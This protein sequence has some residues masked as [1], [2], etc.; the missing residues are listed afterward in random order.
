MGYVSV[1]P[2]VAPRG[3]DVCQMSDERTERR[4]AAILAA[5]VAGYSRLIGQ[6][7][8]RTLARLRAYRREVI[9]PE[10]SGH[11][12][13]LVK[14]TG[15]GFLVEFSS[16]LEALRC[17]TGI[18]QQMAE[19]N[20]G[21]ADDERIDLR[22]GI[23]VGD[24]VVENADIF[25]DGVNVAAR[26][27]EFAA[28]GGICVSGRVHEDA[29]GRLSLNFVDL[30]DQQFKNI[31]HPVRVFAL[32]PE[33]LAAS[34]KAGVPQ[35]TR[36]P[37]VRS[38]PRWVFALGVLILLIGGTAWWWR[39]HATPRSIA[40]APAPVSARRLSVIVLPFSNLS[41]DPQKQYFAD[42]ITEDLTTDLSRIGDSFVI[43]RTTAFTFKDKPVSA[44]EIGQQLGVRYVLE[45]S[46]QPLGRQIRV[47]AQLIEAQTE[48]HVWSQR[49]DRDVANLSDLQTDIT[50]QIAGALRLVLVRAEASRTSNNPD[51]ADLILQGRAVLL[52]PLTLDGYSDAIRLFEQALALDPNSPEAQALLASTLA[53][54]TLDQSIDTKDA[55]LKRA[56][57]LVSRVLAANPD[58]VPGHYAQGSIYRARG[59]W[60]AAAQEYEAIIARNDSEANALHFLGQCRLFT[61]A[62]DEVIP[63]EQKAIH[64]DPLD[65]QIAYKYARIGLVYLLQSRADDAVVWLE[66]A[67]Y[68]NPKLPFVRP[69]LAAAYGL[70]GDKEDAAAE[71]EEARKLSSAGTFQN[72]TTVKTRNQ[73]IFGKTP[74]FNLM[75]DTYFA[76]LL[77]AGL[78]NE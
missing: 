35:P 44:K 3:T 46:V 64:L 41:D 78:P 66:K 27:E 26:L 55:D 13:R 71:L 4:L 11:R 37:A 53:N 51:A 77:K 75:E 17:A 38:P 31:A 6:N 58:Y 50:N 5:D 48:S 24:V 33:T 52:K 39:E 15:D 56:D 16:A 32:T 70:K 2:Y 62:I 10:I 25:G 67:R 18:Q 36:R 74:V 65:P 9:E 1:I 47:N 57:Q 61:G 76:G 21:V 60:A 73:Q 49:Y 8:A 28:P 59:Q 34:P 23:N 63:L 29:T 22:V 68:A 19:R 43:S 7:E 69:W 40:A 72:L 42:G 54:R 12:G 14:T 30:G 45:G 20:A